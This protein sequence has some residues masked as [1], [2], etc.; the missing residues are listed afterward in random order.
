VL[1]LFVAE[2]EGA[3]DLRE[4][5]GYLADAEVEVFCLRRVYS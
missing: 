3:L 5:V 2:V 4:D 1:E